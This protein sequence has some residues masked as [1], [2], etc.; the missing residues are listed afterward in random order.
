MFHNNKFITELKKLVFSKH[1]SIIGNGNKLP[2]SLVYHTNEK[3][4]DIVFT[5]DDIGKV[6]SD[7]D[8]N[9]AHRHMISIHTLKFCGESIHK[10][11]ESIS[12][13]S[14][15]VKSFPP[16]WKN[17]VPIHKKDDKQILKNYRPVSLLP[18]CAKIFERIIYNKIFEYLIK[19]NLITVNQSGFKPG[20]SCINQPLSITH[21]IYKSLDDGFEV[22]GKFLDISKA[23]DK[24]WHEGLIYKLKQ[25]GISGNLLNIIRDFLNSRKQRVVLSG[26]YSSWAS[27]TAGVTQGSILRLCFFL[28]TLTIY[29]KTYHQTPSYLLMIGFFFQLFII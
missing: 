16:E 18:I 20:D 29:Q 14:L 26:Q 11:L 10:P 6:I 1:C 28:F 9:K 17:T 22:K 8:P 23:F 19:T 4:S 21:D 27:I 12:R 25:N 7:L 5:S 15:Y 2:S 3:L 13:A 24:V